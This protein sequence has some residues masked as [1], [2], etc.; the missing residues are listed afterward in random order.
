V[1]NLSFFIV[2]RRTRLTYQATF[3]GMD[4]CIKESAA[5][6]ALQLEMA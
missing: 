3:R 6:G 5:S 4:A 2:A 1:D